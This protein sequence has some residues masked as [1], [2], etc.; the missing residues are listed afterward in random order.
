MGK[1]QEQQ[2]VTP[3]QVL[4]VME[5]AT[6]YFTADIADHLGR[7]PMSI[8]EV[9]KKMRGQDLFEIGQAKGRTVYRVKPPRQ[10]AGPRYL[11]PIKPLTGYDPGAHMRLCNGGRKAETGMA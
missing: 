3:E 6:W 9:M 10:A 2:Q 1:K 4:E 5:P 11:A 7:T 8:V